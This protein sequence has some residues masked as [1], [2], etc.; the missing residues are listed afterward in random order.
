LATLVPVVPTFAARSIRPAANARYRLSRFA[1]MRRN[2]DEIVW[3]SPLAH[4]RVVL[5][6]TRTTAVMGCLAAPATVA[7]LAERVHGLS[8]DAVAG[9]LALLLRAG[10][11]HEVDAAGRLSEDDD[12][13][14]Q[15]W[16]FHDLL[17][18]ARS[19]KGRTDEPYGGTYRF[20]GRSE[21]PPAL[22]PPPDGDAYELCRPDLARLERED[23]PLALVQEQRR[24]VR[25]FD[26]ERPITGRQVG[27]FLFRVARVRNYREMEFPTP[28]G[29]VRMDM[30]SR[31]YPAGGGLYE[32]EL[33]LAVNVCT[34]LA[35]GLHYYDPRQHR[36]IRLPAP[37]ADIAALL[38]DAA[39]STGV[40][41]N[42][43]QVLVVIAARLPRVAWKY[44]S[45]A[46]ALTLKHVGVLYQTMYLAATAMGLAPCGVGGG[47]ADLF[48]R[49]AGA[50]YA[51]ETSVGE[52]LLGSQRPG[53]PA[54]D[55]SNA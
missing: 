40:A 50:D 38:A 17:F 44:D 28:A 15:T 55:R 42:E 10:I 27:E 39:A 25:T 31:P 35:A 3:E 51:A 2:D 5:N 4:A 11:V 21:P 45:I 22:K 12:P 13:A 6:D 37:A 16:A 20:A 14:L 33:Y 46:Y 49:A 41:R 9:T 53:S 26:R 8:A 54:L 36:L 34:D 29:P 24:S 23:P 48:A 43:L 32:L 30:A 19:R 1:Y 47:D 7:E 52:F 18:H